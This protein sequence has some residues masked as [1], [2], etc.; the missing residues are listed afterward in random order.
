[1]E[2]KALMDQSTTNY[3]LLGSVH[4]TDLNIDG[5]SFGSIQEAKEKFDT[6]LGNLMN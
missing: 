3:L 6:A 5:E 2:F 4:A 1:V